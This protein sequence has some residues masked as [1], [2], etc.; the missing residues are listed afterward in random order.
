MWADT[1]IPVP[2]KKTA[3]GVMWADRDIRLIVKTTAQS[4][5]WADTDRRLIVK[6]TA[7]GVIWADTDRRLIVK[8]TAQ[9]IFPYRTKNEKKCICSHDQVTHDITAI[10]CNSHYSTECDV[11]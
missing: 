10:Y 4:V 5:I 6:T 7:Q 9:G 8:T 11:G 1:D 2:V 3:H